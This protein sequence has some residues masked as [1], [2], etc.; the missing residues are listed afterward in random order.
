MAGAPPKAVAWIT[1]DSMGAIPGYAYGLRSPSLIASVSLARHASVKGFSPLRATLRDALREL[2]FPQENPPPPSEGPNPLREILSCIDMVNQAARLPLFESGRIVRTAPGHALLALPTLAN[3]HRATAAVLKWLIAGA[4]AAAS[5]GKLDSWAVQ[6]AP[7]LKSLGR[8][9][10]GSSNVPRFLQAAFERNIQ[11]TT[12]AGTVVQYGQGARARWLDSSFTDATPQLAAMLARNKALTALVLRQNG[13]PVPAHAPARN[14]D[15][16]LAVAG[17]LGYPVVVK[18][19]DLDGGVA[20]AAGLV[21]AEE[22]REA[23]AAAQKHSRHILVEKHIE[24]RDYRLA[25]LHGELLWA[26]ERV[27]AGVAGDGSRTI[28]ALVAAANTDPRRGTGTHA[29]LK[30]LELDDEALGM[31]AG[32]GMGPESI[33]GRGEF[34]PLRRKANIAAG[35]TPVAVKDKVHPDNRRLAIRAAA[36]LRLDI[37]GIDLI[38]PDIARS[39][40]ETGGAVCEVNAQPQL[41]GVTSMHVYGETLKALVPGDGRI[42]LALILGAPPDSDLAADIGARLHGA[43]QGAAWSDSAGVSVAGERIVDGPHAPYPAGRMLILD[44]TVDAACLSVNDDSLLRTGLP[45]DRFDVLVLAGKHLLKHGRENAS[46]PEMQWRSVLAALLPA[47][48]G[49]V[50]SVAGLGLETESRHGMPAD[51]R[52]EPVAR[53][54]MAEAVTAELLAAGVRRLKAG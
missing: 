16:A 42:P 11:T 12:V 9:L 24:G 7:V 36:A 37:A 41:G 22:V 17:K 47:C 29:A 13:I 30:R 27:P 8:L 18:P 38:I 6:L 43:G 28:E 48:T 34:I 44:K 31:L 52:I 2:G 5:G 15:Q 3:G 23:F 4:N 26:I 45:F 40:K 19:A 39:W 21:S 33:P 1:L 35:G 14:V 20:V 53:D 32:R 51:R 54:R 49:K 10:P 46:P 50:L 25:I